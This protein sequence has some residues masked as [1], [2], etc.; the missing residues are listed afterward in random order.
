MWKLV[1]CPAFLIARAGPWLAVLGAILTERC[2]VQRLTDYI[3][4][5]VHFALNDDQF[6]R[7]G[8]VLLA[9]K[10]SVALLKNW[11]DDVFERGEP[12]FDVSH[13]VPYSR[14]FPTPDT[15]ICNGNPVQFKYRQRLETNPSCVT[16]PAMTVEAEPK[17]VV[18]KF[19]T[20]YGDEVHKAMGEAGL[21][22]KL[23]YYGPIDIAPDMPSYGRLKMVVMEYVDGRTAF[24]TQSLPPNFHHRLKKAVEYCHGRGFVFGDLRTPNVMITKDWKVQLIDFDWAGREGEVTYPVSISRN[25]EWPKGVAALEPIFRQHDLDMLEDLRD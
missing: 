4:I 7:V 14:F 3:W 5:P 15:Y 21:A 16:Y 13:P 1:N 2:V 19:V 11:Y 9:L 20:R 22:P 25:I 10:E 17:D 18:V 23:L 24:D 8:H 12:P 6:L